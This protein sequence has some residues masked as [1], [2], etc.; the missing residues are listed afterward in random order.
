MCGGEGGMFDS[1]GTFL[2]HFIDSQ[3]LEILTKVVIVNALHYSQ[4]L[5]FGLQK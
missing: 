4:D 2:K 1:Q 3:K 5:N